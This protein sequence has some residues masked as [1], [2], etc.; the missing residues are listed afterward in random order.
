M[1]NKLLIL[2][3]GIICI[4]NCY[5]E[6]VRIRKIF[7][8]NDSVYFAKLESGFWSIIHKNGVKLYR[9]QDHFFETKTIY[10]SN[11]GKYIIVLADFPRI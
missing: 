5:S 10:V 9:I 4:N 6:D 1:N 8:S 7:T 11:N 2:I 3:T